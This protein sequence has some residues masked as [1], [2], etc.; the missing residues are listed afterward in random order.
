MAEQVEPWIRE[1]DEG[2]QDDEEE[3]QEDVDPFR[4][5]I[6]GWGRR[7]LE[8]LDELQHQVDKSSAAKNEWTDP[9]GQASVALKY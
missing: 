7:H 5:K 3:H 6:A 8:E 1:D 9:D 2:L 4:H